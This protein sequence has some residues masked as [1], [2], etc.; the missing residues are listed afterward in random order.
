[1]FS[2]EFEELIQ[3][4]LEKGKITE[5]DR[6]V[7]RRRG[8]EDEGIEPDELDIILDARL[9]KMKKQS[10]SVESTKMGSVKKCPNCGEPYVPGTY[11][12]KVCG[13]VFQDMDAIKS[14]VKFSEGVEKLS[15]QLRTGF[16]G[17]IDSDSRAKVEN[18]IMNFPVPTT[19]DDIIDFL[20][21]L[22][23]KK[24]DFNSTF[25][26]AYRAKFL[27]VRSKAKILFAGDAQVEAAIKEVT[28]N[29]WQELS[30]DAKTGILIAIY[31]FFGL[32]LIFFG[33][34]FGGAFEE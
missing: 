15:G 22:Y 23:G 12:C 6:E 4:V 26:G 7:L 11:K 32:L 25:Q 5:K 13:H 8:E 18:Y 30:K 20:L 28:G 14:S 19:K 16:F 33:M 1:M 10:E 31:I 27:E 24:S 9:A 34:Y 17:D 21:S 2:P 29:W 3:A